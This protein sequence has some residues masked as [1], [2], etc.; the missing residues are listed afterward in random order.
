[1]QFEEIPKN[2]PR[3]I[4]SNSDGEKAKLIPEHS[5][6]VIKWGQHVRSDCRNRRVASG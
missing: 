4:S 3:R 1:M 2:R 5:V 6:I